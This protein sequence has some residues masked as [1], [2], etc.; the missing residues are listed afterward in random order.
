MLLSSRIQ[1]PSKSRKSESS[2]Y[3]RLQVEAYDK[4][5]LKMEGEFSKISNLNSDEPKS[6]VFCIRFDPEE[7]YI[8]AGT[9]L[10]IF[11]LH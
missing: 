9:L 8:A 7:K 3:T 1:D 6:Q 10:I 5:T 11:R 4:I 2:Y